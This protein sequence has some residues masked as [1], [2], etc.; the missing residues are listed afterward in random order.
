MSEMSGKVHVQWFM[1][2]MGKGGNGKR[3]GWR[4][5]ESV[6]EWGDDEGEGEEGWMRRKWGGDGM[7]EV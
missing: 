6:E 7:I 2:I 5:R 4:K 1:M 3:R